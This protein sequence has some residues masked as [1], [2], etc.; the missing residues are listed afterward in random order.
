MRAKALQ[1]GLR[2][3]DHL[4]AAI[5]RS[6]LAALLK[7]RRTRGEMEP[8]ESSSQSTKR[9][10]GQCTSAALA[11][12]HQGVARR[13]AY[14]ADIFK[15]PHDTMVPIASGDWWMFTW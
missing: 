13:L 10:G 4:V 15:S 6:E 3:H 5:P 7:N 11:S 12:R 1:C 8:V 2:P 9:M 14:I